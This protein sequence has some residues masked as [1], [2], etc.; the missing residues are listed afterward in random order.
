[1][2]MRMTT[3][4]SSGTDYQAMVDAILESERIPMYRLDNQAYEFEQTLNAW[5]TV[6]TS[7]S[8]IKSKTSSLI[9]YSNWEQMSYTNSNEDILS[10][11]VDDDAISSKYDIDVTQLA[12]SHRIASDAQVDKTSELN[13]SGEF[14]IGGSESVTIETTDTLENIVTKINAAST[15][16]DEDEKVTASIIDTTLVLSRDATGLQDLKIS[17]AGD[18]SNQVLRDLG[19]LSTVDGSVKNELQT[20]LNLEMT[21]NNIDVSRSSNTGIDDVIGG[22]TLNIDEEGTT[23]LDVG[24]DTDSIKTL[25]QEFVDA[26]NSA[27]ETVETSSKVDV[28]AGETEASGLLQGE[29]LIRSI[30]D[31][32][33]SLVTTVE[34]D[35]E[36]LDADFN[37][38]RKI[39]IW[40]NSEDNRLA[41]DEEA[42]DSAL[43]SNFEEVEDIFRSYDGGIVR[44]LD[45]YLDGLTRPGD[46]SISRR[47][48]TL[49]NNIDDIDVDISE[50]EDRLT[51]YEQS[52]WEQFARMEEAMS[53]MQS[54]ASFLASMTPS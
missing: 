28:E 44:E 30:K 8:S 7:I 17:E 32:M 19:L 5:N 15:N 48:E 37:S 51:L 24:Q 45:E 16:L 25:I 47:Q 29:S 34:I 18:A 1:M 46:G 2:P 20:G 21:V 36:K 14:T 52:L 26:Y 6:D 53:K 11:D 22:V 4:A 9:S 31:R 23:L 10:A 35:S 3:G 54:G 39:G 13:L 49:Q 41:I 50:M 33:R 27:M 42:L 12:R 40:T 38:L 43:K